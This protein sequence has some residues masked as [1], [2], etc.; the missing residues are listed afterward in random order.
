MAVLVT[1]STST[2][3]FTDVFPDDLPEMVGSTAMGE[4]LGESCGD[5]L[6]P[7]LEA[8]IT[9]VVAEHHGRVVKT[10]ANGVM[11]S[12]PSATDAVR[13]AIRLQRRVTRDVEGVTVR[14]GAAT[15][16]VSWEDDECHGMPVVIAG[17]LQG[18]ARG[19][20]ILV[21]GLVRLLAGERSGA[22][23]DA[24]GAFDLAGIADPVEAF[25]VGWSPAG[26]GD[27]GW[28][29]TADLPAAMCVPPPHPF[30]G[31]AREV[32]ELE[33]AADA[34]R[35][36]TRRTVLI[37]GEAGAGKTRLAFELARRR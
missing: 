28:T 19:G 25:E 12:F 5:D 26:A 21:S 29:V 11:A 1:T 31:R 3:V 22:T 37:G 36:G 35:G 24:L 27:G 34:S 2:I 32:A 23:F 15:G 6:A 30:V 33:E 14:V 10:S 17:R 16:D 18:R 4:R 9:E 20:Q 7:R 13:A 8:V